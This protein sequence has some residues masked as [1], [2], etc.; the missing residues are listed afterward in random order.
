MGHMHIPDEQLTGA[1]LK[2]G[3]NSSVVNGSAYPI[4]W[5]VD[6]DMLLQ[7]RAGTGM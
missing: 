5:D 2:G 4:Q 7:Q 6:F 3:H 1:F